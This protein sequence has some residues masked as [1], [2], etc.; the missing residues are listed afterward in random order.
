MVGLSAKIWSN[1][2]LVI[3]K[4]RLHYILLSSY[5]HKI[6]NDVLYILPWMG[7]GGGDKV[8]L[9]TM[10]GLAGRG[11]TIHCITTM[12][13]TNEW[14]SRLQNCCVEAL[15]LGRLG[16]EANRPWFIKEFVKKRQ[17]K[18]IITSNNLAGYQAAKLLKE[19]GSKVKI[20]DVLHGQGGEHEGGGWPY[21]SVPYADYL[22]SRIVVTEYLKKYMV[23]HGYAKA[24][25]IKVIHNGI[26]ASAMDKPSKPASVFLKSKDK[27]TVLWAGRF[28]REKHPELAIETAL[29]ISKTSSR[30]SVHFILAGG[31]DVKDELMTKVEQYGLEDM[32]TITEKPYKHPS[33]YM[34]YADVLLLTS[35]MEGLPIV[36]LEAFASRLPVIASAVG[37]V[38]EIIC[39]GK[40]GYLIGYGEAYAVDA[41]DKILFL[42]NHR[43]LLQSMREACYSTVS[44][45]FSID[46]MVQ[47]YM[48]ALFSD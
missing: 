24:S 18:A 20:L 28:S 46:T 8:A 4:L 48:D 40:S 9:D 5:N 17:F 6:S 42:L 37:G 7:V 21:F 16:L 3:N 41:A 29:T 19:S 47:S 10:Q 12:P 30:D 38:P 15:D 34:P 33:G 39:D 22:D 25:N 32:V 45:D 11:V 26:E 27:F 2:R 44:S 13:S 1:L 43:P 35:E 14:F 36:I 31:G 23:A